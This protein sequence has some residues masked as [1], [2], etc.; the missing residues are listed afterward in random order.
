MS[1]NFYIDFHV[2]QTVPPSCINRDDT[3]SPKTAYYGGT[4]RSRVSSQAWKHAMRMDF[5][6]IFSSDLQGY[7]TRNLK[8]II[9]K[10]VKENYPEK[11]ELAEKATETVLKNSDLKFDDKKA[12]IFFISSK[13]VKNVADY[14]AKFIDEP[15]RDKKKIKKD[16]MEAIKIDPSVDQALFGRMSAD[17]PELNY[18]AASQVAHSIS[19]HAITNEFD[20][21]TA[22]DDFKINDNA[23]SAHIGTVEFNSSTLYRYSNINVNELFKHLSKEEAA[24]AVKGFAECFIKSMPTGHENSFANRTIPCLVY[25]TIRNDQPVNLCGAFEKAIYSNGDGYEKKSIKALKEYS[26]K[27]YKDFVSEPSL[28]FVIGDDWDDKTERVN[29]NDLTDKLYNIVLQNLND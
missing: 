10:S 1:N 17:N 20:Y 8:D 15:E 24:E 21:F 14:V 2:L 12:V 29:I 4:L 3:N 9:A 16:V 13:Q 19:T 26:E 18:E 11:A 22:V 6:E 7:R 28:S 25:V 27:V 5:K 23:G